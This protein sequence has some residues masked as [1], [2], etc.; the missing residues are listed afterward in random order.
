MHHV[1]I[2]HSSLIQGYRFMY[3]DDHI[4]DF[5]QQNLKKEG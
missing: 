4:Y 2:R 5:Q 1:N 3:W